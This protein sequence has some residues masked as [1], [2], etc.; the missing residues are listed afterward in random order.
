MQASSF[1]SK[2]IR[3]VA[4]TTYQCERKLSSYLYIL[5]DSALMNQRLWLDV[6]CTNFCTIFEYKL[7]ET[8]TRLRSS[9]VLHM[10]CT[11]PHPNKIAWH[12]WG[13]SKTIGQQLKELTG[14]CE[15]GKSENR[16]FPW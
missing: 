15:P 4:C 3:A 7:T 8:T 12:L 16:K 6:W 14:V 5:E 9:R 13:A 2:K 1:C 10:Y 11:F